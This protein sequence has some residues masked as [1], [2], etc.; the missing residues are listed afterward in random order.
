MDHATPFS[1][2]LAE[3]TAPVAEVPP[4]TTPGGR[5]HAGSWSGVRTKN[6][7]T[8]LQA[9]RD[10]GSGKTVVRLVALPEDE[11][12]HELLQPVSLS[13]S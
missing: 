4:P 6:P 13:V 5:R 10:K 11:G 9:F 1:R 8:C 3:A 2:G 12:Q 7:S